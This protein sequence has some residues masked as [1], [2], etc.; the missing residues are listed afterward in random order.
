MGK[1]SEQSIKNLISEIDQKIARLQEG[2]L[3]VHEL[4]ELVSQ[5]AD[6]HERLAVLRFVAFEK[7][8]GKETSQPLQLVKEEI[9][10][11]PKKEE[12]KPVAKSEEPSID[13]SLLSEVVEEEKPT[14]EVSHELDFSTP[15]FSES[16]PNKP[17][18][19]TIK[20]DVKK[21]IEQ[22]HKENK[23]QSSSLHEKFL[24]DEDVDLNDKLKKEDDVPLRKKLGL[25]PITDL[26]TE[27]GIGKKFEYINFLFAGDAKAYETAINELNNAGSKDTAKQKLNVY[28]SVYNWDL[29]DKTIVKFIELV[30]RR[31]L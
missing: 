30:E 26:K 14:P 2:N 9:K 1:N 24:N 31:Y 15:L 20:S 8:A 4:D 18:E 21:P 19:S 10:S 5:A 22:I 25:S 13:F 28:A 17:V 3:A 12:V 11:K 6:L 29:D 16:S 7:F 27:I 23:E